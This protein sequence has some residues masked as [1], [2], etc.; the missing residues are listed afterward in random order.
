MK[1][2]TIN[3]YSF[4]E[5][6]EESKATAIDQCREVEIENYDN[7]EITDTWKAMEK[8]FNVRAEAD[9][10]GRVSVNFNNWR[11][12][13]RELTGARAMAY[14][15]NNF[16]GSILKGKYYSTSGKWIDGKYTYKSLHSK[17]QL[18]YSCPLTG[19]CYDHDGLDPMYNL[20]HGKEWNA[21]LESVIRDCF[22]SLEKAS[23]AEFEYRTSNEG[24]RET[25]EANDWEFTEDG[26][27]Y[28][29]A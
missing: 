25:I 6:S 26:F 1:T 20:M 19:M 11:D 5:L 9:L 18:E 15:W 8:L 2:H 13:A 10:Y 21:T 3:T 24:V 23:I 27:F 14:A 17:C 22:E 29:A 12:E 28:H 16:G 4:A 7:S